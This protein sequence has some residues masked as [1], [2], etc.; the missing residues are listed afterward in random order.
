MLDRTDILKQG[1]ELI[2]VSDDDVSN[3]VKQHTSFAKHNHVSINQR[4]LQDT[5]QFTLDKKL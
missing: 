2:T 5:I 1:G 3:E 4:D